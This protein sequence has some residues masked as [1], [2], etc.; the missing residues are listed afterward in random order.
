MDSNSWKNMVLPG[1]TKSAFNS[2]Q[3]GVSIF[4][5]KN[6]LLPQARPPRLRYTISIEQFMEV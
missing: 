3:R 1:S 6:Y 5:L 2:S 4:V